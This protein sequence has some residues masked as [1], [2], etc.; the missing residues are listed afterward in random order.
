MMQDTPNSIALAVGLRNAFDTSVSELLSFCTGCELIEEA[1]TLSE[2]VHA[3]ALLSRLHLLLACARSGDLQDL[4]CLHVLRNTHPRLTVVAFFDVRRDEHTARQTIAALLHDTLKR[5]SASDAPPPSL[6][7]DD[8]AHL[9]PRQRPHA[10]GITL[11]PRQQH[12]LALIRKGLSNKH[13]ARELG[14]SDGTVKLHCMAI[15]R[16][17]SVANRTQA[18]LVAEGLQLEEP[19]PGNQHM[20]R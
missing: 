11:T 18:A 10:L 15:F 9:P 19:K 16:A 8:A 20:L 12:V 4:H 6:H 7:S 17:L 14:L 5:H 1:R 13:I 3:N 2:I